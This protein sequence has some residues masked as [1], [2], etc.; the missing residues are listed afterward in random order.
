MAMKMLEAGGLEA[1][2]DS[3]RVADEDNPKGYYEEERVKA[4]HELQ[5]KAW[6]HQARGKALKVISYLLMHLPP[7]HRYK[8][9]FMN[10]H[11]DE[12]I[13]SQNKMLQNRGES[14]GQDDEEMK[15]HFIDHLARVRVW[16]RRQKHFEVLEVTYSQILSSPEPEAEKIVRFLG[17]ELDVESMAEVVD[18]TLYRNRR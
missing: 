18:P 15:E 4:L 8:V 17:S 2:T 3:I 5:D 7:D 9:V 16:M 13:A 12:V 6:L 11:P 1:F 14:L 10:R